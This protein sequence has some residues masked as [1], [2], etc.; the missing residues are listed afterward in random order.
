MATSDNDCGSPAFRPRK[1]HT[2]S[3]NGCLA[4]KKQRRKCDELHPRCSRCSKRNTTCRYAMQL[5]QQDPSTRDRCSVSP[6][7]A[8]RRPGWPKAST[9][10]AAGLPP[11]LSVS[12]NGM[13][14]A[15]TLA[16]TELDLLARYLTHTSHVIPVDNVDVF[17][18]QVGIPNLAFC[19][20]PLMDSVLALAA[21]CRGH[22]ILNASSRTQRERQ[23]L[24]DLLILS[25]HRYESSLHQMQDLSSDAS[26]YNNVL[27]NATIMV[28]YGL[29]NHYLRIRLAV[30][31]DRLSND[32]P[33]APLQW[34]S[35]IRAAHLAYT[36][37]LHCSWGEDSGLDS[38]DDSL[39]SL[40]SPDDISTNAGHF[41]QSSS[42]ECST[43]VWRRHLT[44][45]IIAATSPLAVQQLASRLNAASS[46][47]YDFRDVE[48]ATST[49]ACCSEAFA[50]L[51][52]IFNAVTAASEDS[53]INKIMLTDPPQKS[54]LSA[55]SPWL[56]K[57]VAQVTSAIPQKQLRRVIM[58]FLNRVP[59]DFL[60]LVQELLD[61]SV[62]PSACPEA[63]QIAL[64]IF[65][66][67]L[68]LVTLLDDVWWIGG[69]G[70]WELERTVRTFKV[71]ELGTDVE[72]EWW[73]EKM[74]VIRKELL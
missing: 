13:S 73:P 54:R 16:A 67:W 40:D 38:L 15:D 1:S 56:R 10:L 61:N 63:S 7:L 9:I 60:E 43:G 21:V 36:G 58:S 24:E 33:P 69:I 28:L 65:A 44:Q 29:A 66:H 31:D 59:V 19:S 35:L 52:D 2:K 72:T 49:L 12:S 3:R 55:V 17:A 51:C 57:Y 4:C 39:L 6:V 48:E 68:V 30:S 18:L 27:A 62:D 50:V 42:P 74:M 34:T 70:E 32:F 5:D 20:P 64:D 22:E 45:P 8:A 53:P 11:C 23:Q 14:I 25:N 46:V 26:Q 41:E 47:L 37:L 71:F